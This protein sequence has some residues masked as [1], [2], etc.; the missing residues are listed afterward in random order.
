MI[1]FSSLSISLSSSTTCLN[2]SRSSPLSISSSMIYFGS[3]S[4]ICSISIF[5]FSPQLNHTLRSL[6][7]NSSAICSSSSCYMQFI[8]MLFYKSS[9]YKWTDFF[10]IWI[11]IFQMY[12]VYGPKIFT[13]FD[14][15]Y[16][17]Y[18]LKWEKYSSCTSLLWRHIK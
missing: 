7:R 15:S 9:K 1:L 10:D 2:A 12:V 16:L 5:L 18:I 14:T 4:F 3:I 17:R 8:E 13:Q 6:S 11:L